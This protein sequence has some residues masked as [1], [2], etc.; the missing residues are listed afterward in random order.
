[1]RV[2]RVSG[3]GHSVN[4]PAN[5]GGKGRRRR[6]WRPLSD[7]RLR[8]QRAYGRHHLHGECARDRKFPKKLAA[9]VQR[10][11]TGTGVYDVELYVSD[12]RTGILEPLGTS[13]PGK[14][15][16]GACSARCQPIL[17]FHSHGMSRPD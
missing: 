13:G 17:G 12:E 2:E 9:R 7:D 15:A 5:T 10:D 6:S 4:I 11:V 16:G 8:V 3:V 14:L 1:M